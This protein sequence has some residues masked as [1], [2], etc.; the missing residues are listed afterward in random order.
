M[1][2]SS[3]VKGDFS[4]K[5]G[6]FQKQE[7]KNDLNGLEIDVEKT[8]SMIKTQQGCR[9]IQEKIAKDNGL[10]NRLYVAMRPFM[11]ELMIDK[12][13]N[14]LYQ[15]V[16][17]FLNEENSEHFIEYLDDNFEKIS[18]STYG[19]R[20]IQ[21]LIEDLDFEK[22]PISSKIYKIFY[23]R[24]KENVVKMSNDINANY[25]IQKMLILIK[26]PKTDFIFKELNK[27]FISVA[28]TKFG[29]CVIQKALLYGSEMQKKS[30]I[31]NILVNTSSLISNQFGNYV[32][33]CLISIA[34]DN[35][36]QKIYST[37]SEDIIYLSESKYSSNVVEKI[38]DKPNKNLLNQ[39]AGITLQQNSTIVELACNQ[40]GNYIIQKILVSI[41]DE[42][43]ISKI[44]S[45]IFDNSYRI[46]KISFGK[47]FLEK[48]SKKY[49]TFVS[50]F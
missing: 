34:D 7:G 48:L 3:K 30:I 13:G 17:M 39:I 25:I 40:Y 32:Y 10:A 37:I 22:N 19:T 14:F 38:F 11:L 35:L 42:F 43:L 28:T 24:V 2:P 31:K 33:Q 21:K 1:N 12:F 6:I 44:L 45:N 9:S 20:I 47:K 5:S 8:C 26:S 41:T 15:Q 49:P 27:S 46:Q 29:C 23:S 36:M 4:N 16:I 18:F 50:S